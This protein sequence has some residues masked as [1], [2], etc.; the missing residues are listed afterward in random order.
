MIPVFEGVFFFKFSILLQSFVF[1]SLKRL[2]Q[3]GYSEM[4]FWGHLTPLGF[5]KISGL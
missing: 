2:F 5:L 1:V 4:T 3:V